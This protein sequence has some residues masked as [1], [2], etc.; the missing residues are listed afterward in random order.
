MPIARP[1]FLVLSCLALAGPLHAAGQS[2]FI[3]KSDCRFAPVEPAAGLLSAGVRWSGA[4]KDGYAEGKGVLEWSGRDGLGTRKLE[5][6][7]ARGEISGPGKLSYPGGSYLGSLRRG[8]PHGAGYFEY[9][10]GAQY[11]GG[12]AE[13]RP[14][15]TGTRISLDG[16]TY[17]GEWKGGKRHG[18]GK[19]VFTLGGRYEGEWRDDVFNGQGT[20]VYAGS[21]RSWSGE[22][23]DGYPA[24]LT[25]PR[26]RTPGNDDDEWP[27]VASSSEDDDVVVDHR[28]TDVG[29]EALPA[30]WKEKVRESYPALDERDEPPYLLAGTGTKMSSDFVAYYN[31]YARVMPEGRIRVYVTVGPDG[32]P[33][34]VKLYRTP[35]PDLGRFV[36]MALMMQRFKPALC[37]GK[38]CEMVYPFVFDFM[39]R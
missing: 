38:P 11:E 21:G 26:R 14:E 33:S 16:S 1:S 31:R 20:I 8:I 2:D 32:V 39:F 25:P 36:S 28:V 13:G 6:V 34:A 12:V 24:G 10:N 3:G 35:H 19:A 18:R 15:G 29:W 5:V 37:A 7:L 30:A 17:E 4:C 27:G 22:F 23:R 9:R